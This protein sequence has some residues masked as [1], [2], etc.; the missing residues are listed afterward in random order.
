MHSFGF[1]P[2]FTRRRYA[3]FSPAGD[4][5]STTDG[6]V[7]IRG[8]HRLP[9]PHIRDAG[10]VRSELSHSGGSM[11]NPEQFASR[12]QW[13]G[14]SQQRL[15]NTRKKSERLSDYAVPVSGRALRSAQA[16]L[17][18]HDCHPLKTHKSQF[19]LR[20]DTIPSTLTIP[21]KRSSSRA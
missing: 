3:A 2:N 11:V 13:V 12:K 20:I 6:F 8:L 1:R 16:S 4:H 17:R 10:I 7:R 15:W 21:T 19:Y 14:A 5:T 18:H 9:L